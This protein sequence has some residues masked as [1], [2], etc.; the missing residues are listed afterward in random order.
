MEQ[1]LSELQGSVAVMKCRKCGS[2]VFSVAELNDQSPIFCDRCGS[3]VDS[4]ADVRA[5]A[6]IPSSETLEKIGANIVDSIYRG[7][8]EFSLVSVE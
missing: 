6:N 2:D 4:W 3:V 1:D 5:I 8:A 7:V